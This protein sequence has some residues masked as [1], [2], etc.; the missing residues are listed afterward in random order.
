MS[1]DSIYEYLPPESIPHQDYDNLTNSN[2]DLMAESV[3]LLEEYRQ[4]FDE[5]ERVAR[6][7]ESK[8][9]HSA[10]AEK[11]PSFFKSLWTRGSE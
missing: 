5:D 6:V 8:R 11:R 1:D 2:D 4:W 10:K 9:V 3:S 7:D